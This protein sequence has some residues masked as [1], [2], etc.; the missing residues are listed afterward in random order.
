[1]AR[2]RIFLKCMLYQLAQAIERFTQFL[3]KNDN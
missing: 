2:K 3:M 1:M